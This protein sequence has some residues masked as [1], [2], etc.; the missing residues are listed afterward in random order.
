MQIFTAFFKYGERIR[1]FSSRKMNSKQRFQVCLVI[2]WLESRRQREKEIFFSPSIESNSRSFFFHHL[3][4]S[5]HSSKKF[6]NRLSTFGY[7]DMP[8]S[9]EFFI[10]YLF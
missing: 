2:A 3:M 1:L 8:P 9:Y 7:L 5:G 4:L 10:I 6:S